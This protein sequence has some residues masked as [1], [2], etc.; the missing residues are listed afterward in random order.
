MS[1]PLRIEYPGALYHVTS[2]GDRKD[3]IFEDD[4]DRRR[5]LEILSEVIIT[6]NWICHA[7]CLMGNHY[8][9][10]IETP[11]GHLSHG[12]RQLNGIFTQWSNH[13]HERVGHLFQGRFKSI[14]IDKDAHLLELSRYVVLNPVRALMVT[15]PE[16]WPWSSYRSMLGLAACDKWLFT[17]ELLALFSTK[18]SDAIQQ[19]HQFVMQPISD[20]IWANLKQQIYLG[21]DDFV[22]NMQTKREDLSE[23]VGI[24]KVQKCRPVL[25]LDEIWSRNKCRNEAIIASYATGHYSYQQIADYCDLHFT[26]VGTI[27]RKARVQDS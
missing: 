10:V 11:E 16:D 15:R 19:Y 1:R 27:I 20:S 22:V 14:L 9:L 23:I 12:M 5:F 21:D 3:T 26:T 13:R 18:R 25:S 4:V 2:R 7:Y 6:D 17:D 24:P 8:H